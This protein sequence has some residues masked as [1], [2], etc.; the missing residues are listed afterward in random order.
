M[1]FYNVKIKPNIFGLKK[2]SRLKSIQVT[3]LIV[4]FSHKSHSVSNMYTD[5]KIIL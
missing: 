2:L 1:W 4:L 3:V 5:I